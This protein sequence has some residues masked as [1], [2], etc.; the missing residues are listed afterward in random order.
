MSPLLGFTNNQFNTPLDVT[1][2]AFALLRPL[3][4]YKSSS[5]ARIKIATATG[6]GFSETA[7]QL[8]GFARPLWVVADL[9]RLQTIDPHL[10]WI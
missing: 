2:A 7:A 5:N 1:K 10:V 8:E 6:A 9:L 4:S 3:E